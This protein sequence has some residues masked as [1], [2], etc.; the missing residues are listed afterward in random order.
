MHGWRIRDSR[1]STSSS[2]Q[3]SFLNYH[4]LSN[5][6]KSHKILTKS[7]AVL[8]W[9]KFVVKHQQSCIF[10]RGAHVTLFPVP[11][12]PWRKILPNHEVLYFSPIAYKTQYDDLVLQ[13]I[14]FHHGAT[15]ANGRYISI[16]RNNVRLGFLL[17]QHWINKRWS[18]LD[19]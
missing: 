16:R 11:V 2:F 3:K 4:A 18:L 9:I 15:L 19:L 13:Q 12:Q 7:R 14:L 10:H 8:S 6:Q 1:R 17:S 5:A